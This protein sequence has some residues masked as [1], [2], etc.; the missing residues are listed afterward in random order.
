MPSPSNSVVVASAGSRKTTSIVEAALAVPAGNVL[1]TTYTIENVNQI[2]SYLIQRRGHIPANIAVVSWFSFLLQDGVRPYQNYMT[3]K[4]RITTVNFDYQPNRYIPKSNADAYFL[5]SGNNIYQ[6]RVSDFVCECDN[7]SGGLVIRRLEK[8]YSHVF[9]DELQDLAGYD[10]DL[11][12]KLFTSTISVVAVGDPR[13]ATFSTNKSP[14][15]KK[16]KKKNII[17]WINEKHAAKLFK[18]EQLTDCYR[19][20]QAICDFA[21]ALFPTLPKTVSKNL[22]ITGHDGVFFIESHQVAEY[23]NAHKPTVLRHDKRT[24]T[25]ELSALNIGLSKGR[26]Y[27]R[28]L[29]FPTN[30]MKLYLDTKDL[31]KAGDLAKL[32]VAV[33]RAKFSVAFVT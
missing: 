16:Y 2:N 27:E 14:K 21:D 31:S 19:S 6:D 18:L 12:E 32:Y 8:I 33:T 28:V 30:P 15:N 9:I 20:N 4:G 17:D 29:I 3:D 7:R 10:L 23:L 13:Q 5:T 25:M 11:L 22:T 24:H 26:T 1:I